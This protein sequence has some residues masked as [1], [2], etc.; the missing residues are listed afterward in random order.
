VTDFLT[1]LVAR[2]AASDAGLRPRPVSRFEPQPVAGEEGELRV[3]A[4]PRLVNEPA[5][6]AGAAE[7]RPPTRRRRR[8]ARVPPPRVGEPELEPEPGE[9]PR[10]RRRRPPAPDRPPRAEEPPR[11]VAPPRPSPRE[12][13][14]ERD[15]ARSEPPTGR[16][17]RRRASSR[18]QAAE[19]VPEAPRARTVMVERVRIVPRDE[20]V[21]SPAR[22]PALRPAVLQAATPAATPAAEPAPDVHVTIGR[23]EVRAV[24]APPAPAAVER[25]PPVMTLEEYLRRRA[26]GSS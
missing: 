4:T 13:R 1:N 3:G 6:D 26:G 25:R 22:Q 16:A 14:R 7:P 17:Q 12:P 23:I 15:V 21:P 9:V 20:L 24:P 2:A 11:A 8:P 5:D 10:A 19:P 18:R